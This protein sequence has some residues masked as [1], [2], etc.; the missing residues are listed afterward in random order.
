MKFEGQLWE[1]TS[2]RGAKKKIRLPEIRTLEKNKETGEWEWD[3]RHLY[4]SEYL[5]NNL[6]NIKKNAQKYKGDLLYVVDGEEG[7]G[8]STLARQVAMVLD[9]TFDE[10]RI[11]Y[12]TRDFMIFHRYNKPFTSGILDESREQLDRKSTMSKNNKEF[13]NFLSESRQEHKFSCLVLPSIYD[14]D[15]YAAEHRAKF[16]I[17]CYKYKGRIPG[18]FKFYG[19]KGIQ[20]LF[21]YCSKD[22]SYTVNPS[23]SGSFLNQQVCD[24]DEYDKRKRAALDKYYIKLEKSEPLTKEDII[25]EYIMH[26]IENIPEDIPKL[27]K[28]HIAKIFGYSRQTIY[29]WEKEMEESES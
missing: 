27:N 6:Y 28:G 11:Y 1:V 9:Q 22:R 4:M 5:F 25:K 8:K 17:H 19:K 20:R 24:L 16:L 18:S 10:K 29:A 23:F 21:R 26:R 14:L 12:S 2:A 3:G 13:N 7:S 15:K